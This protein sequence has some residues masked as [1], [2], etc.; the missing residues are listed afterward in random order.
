MII[1][2]ENPDVL[3]TICQECGLSFITVTRDWSNP[4]RLFVCTLLVFAGISQTPVKS[5]E[6][7]ATPP[8]DSSTCPY[9]SSF[10]GFP[11]GLIN[12]SIHLI[13]LAVFLPT[14]RTI[15]Y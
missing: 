7:S 8:G 11:F 1:L 4:Y 5:P 10:A 3:D 14:R 9:F 15:S 13:P 2:V 6:Y 12:R